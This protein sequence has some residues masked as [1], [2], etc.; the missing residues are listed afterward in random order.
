MKNQIKTV[1][2]LGSLSALVIGVGA[3]VAPGYLYLFAALALAMNLGA[4]FFSDRLVLRM[5][6]AREVG[7]SE[8]PELHAIVTELSDKAGIPKPRLYV[9]PEEQPN[10]FAT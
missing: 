7:P 3:L 8:A 6:H 9:I 5:H 1:V 4:Y 2:L 10:A